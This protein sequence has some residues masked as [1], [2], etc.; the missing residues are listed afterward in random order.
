MSS[1]KY[2]SNIRVRTIPRKPPNIQYPIVLATSDTS[3]QYQY[4]YYCV[5][6][7]AMYLFRSKIYT[8]ISFRDVTFGGGT[9][10]PVHPMIDA[11]GTL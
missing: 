1:S 8:A 2:E 5:S 9:C 4:R 3:T 7:I 11:H 6:Y 10:P